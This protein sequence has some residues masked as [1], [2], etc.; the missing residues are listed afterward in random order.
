M[1]FG[2]E[3]RSVLLVSPN[4]NVQCRGHIEH[5]DDPKAW[6]AAAKARLQ[7]AKTGDGKTLNE[8]PEIFES[9]YGKGEWEVRVY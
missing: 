5:D 3:T 7:S 9:I 2:G 1:I 6:G 8:W 4:G